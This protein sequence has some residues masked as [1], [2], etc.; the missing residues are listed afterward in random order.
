LAFYNAI[1]PG[2][3]LLAKR[4]A[5]ITQELIDSFKQYIAVQKTAEFYGIEKFIAPT[6]KSEKK[7]ET[8]LL[9]RPMKPKH[10]PREI[11]I[12]P[13]DNNCPTVLWRWPAPPPPLPG[14]D[15]EL[16][17]SQSHDSSSDPGCDSENEWSEESKQRFNSPESPVASS[18]SSS[19]TESNLSR[20]EW[21]EERSQTTNS[22]KKSR[23]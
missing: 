10:P 13:D 18:D 14:A 20:C 7:F 23:Q 6:L 5:G 17:S 12:L 9:A 22:P 8:R 3:N 16:N 2:L 15:K 1:Q 11:K 19:D 4:G 21:G